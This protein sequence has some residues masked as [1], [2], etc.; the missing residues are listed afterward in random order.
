MPRNKVQNTSPQYEYMSLF[1]NNISIFI[2]SYK[3]QFHFT[4]LY[5]SYLGVTL[6][7]S[8]IAIDVTQ[9]STQVFNSI[10]SFI[11]S[12]FTLDKY[13]VHVHILQI[14]LSLPPFQTQK[15]F[16]NMLEK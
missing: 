1:I 10:T 13:T 15:I 12:D 4:L 7:L 8:F 14:V 16:K 5:N 6:D 11:C 3:K 2:T 9:S